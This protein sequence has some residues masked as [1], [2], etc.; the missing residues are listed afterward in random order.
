[1]PLPS[2]FYF[3]KTKFLCWHV[4]AFYLFEISCYLLSGPFLLSFDNFTLPAFSSSFVHCEG[5]HHLQYVPS[6][7]SYPYLTFSVAWNSLHPRQCVKPWPQM[8]LTSPYYHQHCSFVP[9]VGILISSSLSLFVSASLATAKKA[10]TSK[11]EDDQ[12]PNQTTKQSKPHI[13]GS[14]TH[15]GKAGMGSARS[16]SIRAN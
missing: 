11:E 13:P 12:K 10:T 2:L 16:H 14:F 5:C 6:V 7:I 8:L 4:F 3:W 15:L 1:M 9:G